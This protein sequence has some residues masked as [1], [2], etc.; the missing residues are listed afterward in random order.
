MD[1]RPQSCPPILAADEIDEHYLEQENDIVN[2]NIKYAAFGVAF[3]LAV[4]PLLQLI[5]CLL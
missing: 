5:V 3:Y 2:P 1:S 4:M